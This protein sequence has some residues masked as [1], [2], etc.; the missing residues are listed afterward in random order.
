MTEIPPLSS[1][2]A[3]ATLVGLLFLL[4]YFLAMRRIWKAAGHRPSFQFGDYFRATKRGAF[5]EE[6][7]PE[8][9]YAARQFWFGAV[10]LVTGLVLYG[11]LFT[12]GTPVTLN[13]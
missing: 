13:M 5:G 12:T 7:E 2:A 9:R 8:R 4:R 1:I 11:W 10:L 3:A 6:L